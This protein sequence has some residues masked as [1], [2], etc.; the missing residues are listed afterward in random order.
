MLN[1]LGIIWYPNFDIAAWSVKEILITNK[2]GNTHTTANTIN[3]IW[4]RQFT[5]LFSICNQT[6]PYVKDFLTKLRVDAD[7]LSSQTINSLY[8][9]FIYFG[10]T[11]TEL[12]GDSSEMS[13]KNKEDYYL[14][15]FPDKF[16]QVIRENPEKINNPGYKKVIRI[17]HK[18]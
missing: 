16:K 12:F 11:N 9:D 15:Q 14:N 8:K 7:S 10:L 18:I 6:T 4:K 3:I 1:T 2:T 5:T 13:M 17:K